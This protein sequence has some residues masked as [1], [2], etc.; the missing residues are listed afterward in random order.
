MEPDALMMEKNAVEPH[1]I[2]RHMKKSRFR[3]HRMLDL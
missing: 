3:D 2:G 1:R